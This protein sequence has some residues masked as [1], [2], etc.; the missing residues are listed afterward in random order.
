MI[1]RQLEKHSAYCRII[2]K[3]ME[4]YF[5]VSTLGG[6]TLHKWGEL[7]VGKDEGR[8]VYAEPKR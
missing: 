2:D 5:S 7:T 6:S 3:K 8:I 4:Y 1:I